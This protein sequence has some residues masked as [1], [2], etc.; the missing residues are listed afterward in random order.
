MSF[1]GYFLV[2]WS[3][4]PIIDLPS[5]RRSLGEGTA[6]GPQI[7]Q[8]LGYRRDGDWQMVQCD[9]DRPQVSDLVADT[10]APALVIFTFES[11]VADVRGASPTGEPWFAI[12]NPDGAREYG[13]PDA[14]PRG[15][16]ALAASGADAVVAD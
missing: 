9:A 16:R 13:A 1:N 6:G 2:A 4:A 12:L 15:L 8:V 7:D 14:S 11:W 10:H 3:Q 5:V